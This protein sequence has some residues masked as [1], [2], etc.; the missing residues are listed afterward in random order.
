[1]TEK[2][3]FALAYRTVE[4][5][6]IDGPSNLFD[7]GGVNVASERGRLRDD[8]A[9]ERDEG[10]GGGELRDRLQTDRHTSEK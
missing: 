6:N 1:M 10:R 8:R 3:I 2:K 9:H 4:V 5:S 7:L